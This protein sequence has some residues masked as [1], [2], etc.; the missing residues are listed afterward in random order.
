MTWAYFLWMTGRFIF[1]VGPV[2]ISQSLAQSATAVE[3]PITADMVDT[4]PTLARTATLIFHYHELQTSV[5][6]T[7]DW[8]EKTGPL[9]PLRLA[10]T[11]LKRQTNPAPATSHRSRP[12]PLSP[13]D[14]PISPPGMEKSMGRMDH[15][16]TRWAP[17]AARRLARS[18]PRWIADITCRDG[19]RGRVRSGGRGQQRVGRP[20]IS[21][22]KSKQE[23]G[24][25]NILKCDLFYRCADR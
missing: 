4:I 14:V 12:K 22:G 3:E 13:P 18:R 11:T 23:H 1:M 16:W 5:L 9:N 2:K 24:H 25:E 19:D 17:E 7:T 21:R 15:F 20:I 10:S 8:T 6:S